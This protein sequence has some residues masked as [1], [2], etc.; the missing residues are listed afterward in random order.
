MLDLWVTEWAER[1]RGWGER[2]DG[3]YVA[4]RYSDHQDKLTEMR[5]REAVAYLGR[6]P[7]EYSY[8][9]TE[10]YLV[11]VSRLPWREVE[12]LR[13]H[14]AFWSRDKVRFRLDRSAG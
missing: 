3:F 10:P 7:D 6:V 9:V 2:F 14:G 5:Q 1:E 4:L 8:P 12:S 11:T 13:D